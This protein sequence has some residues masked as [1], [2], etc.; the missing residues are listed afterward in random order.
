VPVTE[1]PNLTRSNVLSQLVSRPHAEI[2][3]HQR[4]PDSP[5]PGVLETVV[6]SS[7]TPAPDPPAPRDTEACLSLLDAIYAADTQRDHVE[8]CAIRLD[9]ELSAEVI[10]EE[11]RGQAQGTLRRISR[12]DHQW[13]LPQCAKL[14]A[15][16]RADDGALLRGI[17][18]QHHA[19]SENGSPRIPVKIIWGEND[20][21]INVGV[22]KNFQSHLKHTSLRLIPAGHWLQID[23]PEQVAKEMLL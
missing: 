22:A 15:S 13:Q 21:S 23:E 9:R 7:R 1:A 18:S 5:P 17:R 20:P 10:Q 2:D 11:P 4:E 16:I 3:V 8:P 14:R 12:P 6:V 19:H